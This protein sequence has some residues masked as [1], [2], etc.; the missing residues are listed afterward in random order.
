[1][2]KLS[3]DT[4]VPVPSEKQ[5]KKLHALE[6]G[7]LGMGKLAVAFSGGVDST[8]LLAVA[9]RVLG[10]KVLAVISKTPLTPDREHEQA[11]A[12]CRG[13]SVDCVVVGGCGL[14]DPAFTENPPERCYLCKKILLSGIKDAALKRGF[15]KLA[16]GSN[17]DDCLD[18]RPGSRA[19]CEL[20]VSSP[21]LEAGMSK[22]D[23]RDLSRW[24]GLPTWDKPSFACLASR[25]PYGDPITE[26]KLLQVSAAEQHLLDL[27]VSSVRVR[28]H[29]DIARIEAPADDLPLLFSRR[30]G[31]VSK[32]KGLGYTYVSLDLE[33]YRT[34]SM[35]A[36]LKER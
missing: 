11:L 29:G 6:R 9:E 23:I 5:L 3:P 14:D 10:G 13:L 19:V 17:A 26:E 22:R 16:E 7:L 1:M 28:V 36:V 2:E 21:L 18:Y 32:L 25:F 20:G 27:G 4:N 35:N 24:M 33:G 15:E 30:E 8:F 12:L 31:I 34:G